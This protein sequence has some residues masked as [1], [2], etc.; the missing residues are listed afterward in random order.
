MTINY[1]K[2]ACD[3]SL[4]RTSIINKLEK[5]KNDVYRYFYIASRFA[6]NEPISGNE[7]FK[8]T[9]K[10]F[11][12]MRTAGLSQQHFD[13]YFELLD[14]RVNNLETILNELYEIKTLK[15]QNSLQFSF[16]TKLLHTIDNNLPIYDNQVKKTLGLPDTY[17]IQDSRY[18]KTKALLAYY[19]NLKMIYR[20]LLEKAPIKKLIENIRDHFRW[21]ADQIGDVKILDFILWVHSQ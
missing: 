15:Q 17:N 11:Y 4:S 14:R 16:S 12:V 2:L 20:Q 7:E 6:Q 19:S 3:L 13:K 18:K 9:Y 10:S 21:P 5:R 8:E 1:D